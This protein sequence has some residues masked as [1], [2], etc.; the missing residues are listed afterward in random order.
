M[1][2][3][4]FLTI[5]SVWLLGSISAFAQN[6]NAQLVGID[7]FSQAGCETESPILVKVKFKVE[8]VR[9]EDLKI[10]I[11]Y[12]DNI[13]YTNSVKEVDKQGNITYS[14]CTNGKEEVMFTVVFSKSNGDKSNPIFVKPNLNT[15]NLQDSNI[16]AS[17]KKP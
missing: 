16:E 11:K 8:N 9:P 7:F 4:F 12:P 17:K 10:M 15:A 3:I 5:L 14:Y 2:K 1:K 6:I 13:T